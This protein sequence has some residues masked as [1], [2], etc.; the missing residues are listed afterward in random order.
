MERSSHPTHRDPATHLLDHPASLL[1]GIFFRIIASPFM[2]FDPPFL[3]G[4]C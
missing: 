2:A 3:I 4:S 1:F